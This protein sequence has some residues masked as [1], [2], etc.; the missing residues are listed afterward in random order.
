MFNSAHLVENIDAPTNPDVLSR[1]D[2][3]ARNPVVIGLI[4]LKDQ[5]NH[6]R[7]HVV[8]RY[9]KHSADGTL[10][11]LKGMKNKVLRMHPA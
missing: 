9:S 7:V 10:S 2:V 3:V 5:G 1:G 4:A 11:C 8:K 6:N